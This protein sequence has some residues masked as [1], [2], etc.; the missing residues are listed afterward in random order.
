LTNIEKYLARWAE[1]EARS[2]ALSLPRYEVG[3]TV[4]VLGESSELFD[5]YAGAAAALEGRLLLVLVVNSAPECAAELRA[6]NHE[7][8]RELRHASSASD[9]GCFVVERSGF[10][11]L[12][13]DRSSPGREV[14]RREGVG[15]ARKIGA[16][17]LLGLVARGIIRK[18]LICF[19]D[20]D[21]ELPSDYF[22]RAE[23]AEPRAAALLFPFRHVAAG[24][25]AAYEATLTYEAMLR[26]HVLGLSWAGSPYAF[27]S[28]G[29]T[30]AVRAEHYATVRGVPRRPAGEDFYLLDKLAKVAPLARL[31]GEPVAVR[32]RRS[33]RVP[34]GT[35]PRVA[36]ILTDGDTRVAAP[37]AFRALRALLLG[38]DAFA[39][40]RELSALGGAFDELP[41]ELRDAAHS[42]LEASGLVAAALAASKDVGGGNLQRRIHTWFDALK[43]LRFL[44]GLAAAGIAERPLSDAVS[45]AEFCAAKARTSA[46]ELVRHLE[47]REALLPALVGPSLRAPSEFASP[48]S[49]N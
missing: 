40:R 44:H 22:A 33:A 4:P 30:L 14:S 21:A 47:H 6:K 27:H 42:A 36:K 17:L 48:S 43:T 32:A 46:G 38:I 8:L 1:P 31:E 23:L 13:V 5:G 11:V 29:S 9:S 45:D 49:R 26:Y 16:D 35:G 2:L 3:V 25:A 20:A 7:L 41:R 37:D 39:I 19:T 34:F 15:L 28:I 18:S 12:V 24:D 10:D